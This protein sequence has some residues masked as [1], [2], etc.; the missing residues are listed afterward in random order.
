MFRGE[1]RI[2]VVLDTTAI[3]DRTTAGVFLRRTDQSAERVALRHHV[4]GR[5]VEVSWAALRDRAFRVATNLVKLAVEPGDRVILMSENRLEWLYIDAGIQ[6][7][8]AVTVP[9]Y[10]STMPATAQQIAENSGAVV[11]IT[12]GERL[13]AKLESGGD[14]RRILRMDREIAEWMQGPVL[15]AET[16]EVERRL[17]ELT[18]DTVATVIYTSGTTGEPKGVVLAHRNMVDM[19]R[20]C[21]EAFDIGEDDVALS[22]LPYSHVLE[23]VNS[24]LVGQAAGVTG[25][26][27]RGVDHLAEDIREVRP[28]IMVSV[29]RVYEKMHD[30]VMDG[31]RK[32]PASRRRLFNWAI[33]VGKKRAAG[34][35]TVTHPLAER[36]VL[37]PLRNRLTGGRL[38]YFVSGGAPLATEVEEFF[39]A[40]G[41]KILQ[42][43]GMTETTSGATSNTE[44]RH[45]YATVGPALPGV[46]LKIAGD[47][48]ILV[49]GPG[50]MLGYYRNQKATEEI[51]KDGWLHTGDI[52]EI[53]A[54]GFL[55]ITDRKKDLIKTSGGKYV[56][57]QPIEAALQND[58]LIER[59]VVVGDER[60]YCVALIVPN[61]DAAGSRLGLRG[62]HEQLVEDQRLRDAIQKVVDGVNRD[63]GSWESIKYFKLLPEDFSEDAGEI[64]PTLKV[65]RRVVQERHAGEIEELY[66]EG[67]SKAPARGH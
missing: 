50:V 9:I 20:S 45:R 28:T 60:P 36:L 38:R 29:P 35:F 41:V 12:S 31:V 34:R 37:R 42:G 16:A 3:S 14:L 7:A 13:A 58:A 44:A 53:D 10:P 48:E 32:A 18:P 2:I 27:S 54:D 6:L 49:K 19:V 24:I 64:T 25:Y 66:A 30:A 56:A 40:L 4:D 15:E 59:A 22:F 1:R 43:W 57:P 55:K 21:L 46:E 5:W 65:K 51:L 8:G 26:L 62:D 33:A 52:G 11:A 23:R 17:R 61:W 47:G 63:L 39:W 67:K